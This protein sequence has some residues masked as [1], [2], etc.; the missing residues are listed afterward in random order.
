MAVP[1]K[2]TS[3]TKTRSR[4]ANWLAKA[5]NQVQKAWSLAKSVAN[6]NSTSFLLQKSEDQGT[7]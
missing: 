5:R 2:R 7:N 6:P 4:Q 3:K 1:K